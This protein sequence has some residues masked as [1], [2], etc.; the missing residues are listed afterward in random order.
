MNPKIDPTLLELLTLT[1]T[2]HK[3]TLPSIIK[4]TQKHWLRKPGTERWHIGTT[5]EGLRPQLLPLFSK[6]DMIE[7]RQPTQTAYDYVLVFGGLQAQIQNRLSLALTLWQQGIRYKRLIFLLGERPLNPEK[8]PLISHPSSPK[9]EA[10]LARIIFDQTDLPQGFT[11]EI[12]FISSPMKQ[13]NGGLTRPTTADTVLKWIATNP[14]PGT[15]LA[16]SNQPFVDYQ[17]AVLTTLLPKSFIAETIGY[18]AQ[19][20]IPV[21]E[22]LDTLARRLYQENLP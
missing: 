12:G 10:D 14:S 4:A 1:K 3:G 20:D 6:L 2:L 19:E 22:I 17:Q 11:A 9:T 16:V 21:G 13:A 5:Y 7:A 8:E 15:I 18:E